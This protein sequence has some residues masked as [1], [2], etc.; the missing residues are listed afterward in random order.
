MVARLRV[1][2][3]FVNSSPPENV[4]LDVS[5]YTGF[6]SPNFLPGTSTVQNSSVLFVLRVQRSFRWVRS[7]KRYEQMYATMRGAPP[8]LSRR[9]MMRASLLATKFIAALAVGPQMSGSAKKLN[10]T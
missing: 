2:R 6:L 8:P 7:E 5:T 1:L 10:F 9:S 4:R 3:L